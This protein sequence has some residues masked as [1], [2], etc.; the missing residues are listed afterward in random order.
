MKKLGI[1][2][3]VGL[4]IVGGVIVAWPMND[5]DD[6]STIN[7]STTTTNTQ[8]ETLQTT[9]AMKQ[10][11]AKF[12]TY[13]G[14]DYDRYYIANMIGHHESAVDMAEVALTNAK[15]PELKT[16]ANNIISAQNKE[17][18]T[19][20]EWQKAWGYPPSSGENMVDHSAMNMMEDMGVMND[21]LKQL[22]GD[23]FDKAFLQNM[24]VHHESAIAM[25][26]PG[27]DNAQ[28]QEVKGLTKAVIA[29]QTKEVLQ[30]R[31]WQQEWGYES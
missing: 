22:T 11:E 24:I 3:A 12:R 19:M 7:S 29:D 13:V 9:E 10:E 18:T 25:S 1:T 15:H 28:H 23:E 16:L 4:L 20:L 14:E 21:K 6:A 5:Q 26:R 31:Q 17:I 8:Q 2:L 27:T 30:M